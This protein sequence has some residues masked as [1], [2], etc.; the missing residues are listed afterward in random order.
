VKE[1]MVTAKNHTKHKNNLSET[2]TV[3]TV[4]LY[5]Y[6]T[7]IMQVAVVCQVL[8]VW[9]VITSVTLCA[10]C[11]PISVLRSIKTVFDFVLT[12]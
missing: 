3:C 9:R 7:N 4:K 11:V 2:F 6:S 5:C 12:T 8:S 1:S 10:R